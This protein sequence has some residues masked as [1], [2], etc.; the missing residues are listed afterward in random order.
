MIQSSNMLLEGEYRLPDG[1]SEYGQIHVVDGLIKQIGKDIGTATAVFP[2][3]FKIYP[4]F[5]DIHVHAREYAL[6]PSPSEDQIREQERMLDKEDYASVC[7]AAVNGGV[8]AF[9]DMPNNPYPP[10]DP[11]SY[12]T[13]ASLADYRCTIDHVLYALLTPKS[14]PFGNIP[15]KGYTHDMKRKEIRGLFRRFSCESY[16][17]LLVWHCEN[18]NII[19]KDPERPAE[20]EIYDVDKIMNLSAKFKV[21]VHIS[22]VSSAKA[23]DMIVEA[24]CSGVSVTCETTPSYLYFSDENL[25]GM[26][27]RRMIQMK[28]P[29][30]TEYDRQRMMDG[31][32]RGDIDCLATDHAPHTVKDKKEGAFGIPL[33]DNYTGFVGWLLQNGILR[34]RIL[35]ACCEFPGKFIGRYIG[36]R[37][38]KIKVGYVGSFTVVEKCYA[39]EVRNAPPKIETKCGWSPFEGVVLGDKYVLRAAETIVRGV[40]MKTV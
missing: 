27:N 12:S 14:E 23:L 39:E 18:S 32:M 35:E 24:K 5:I 25:K 34:K 17:P 36:D 2:E 16:M 10:K 26:K 20:A 7:A 15:Y 11:V 13:K 9:A 31:L 6:P 8:V 33:L 38:G 21:P 29:L 19:S 1:S 3:N 22:H 40:R 37:F 30:R 4:G 28:P